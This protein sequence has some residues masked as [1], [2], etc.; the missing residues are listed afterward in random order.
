MAKTALAIR[1][2]GNKPLFTPYL[3]TYF[4]HMCIQLIIFVLMSFLQLRFMRST[5]QDILHHSVCLHGSESH[6]TV[7][8]FWLELHCCFLAWFLKK[9]FLKKC[10]DNLIVMVSVYNKSAWPRH[11]KQAS[12]VCYVRTYWYDPF[13]GYSTF[14][15]DLL[16]L[17]SPA[18]Y[19]IIDP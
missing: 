9:N 6:C 16:P 14:L 10:L 15:F 17:I 7:L 18:W 13:K 19:K 3:L 1:H 4:L 8:P 11:E 2:Y 5:L 12:S